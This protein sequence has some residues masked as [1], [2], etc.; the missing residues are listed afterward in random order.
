M[1]EEEADVGDSLGLQAIKLLDSDSYNAPGFIKL[2]S[3]C[4]ISTV[5]TVFEQLNSAHC[6]ERLTKRIT[7]T[8]RMTLPVFLTTS[9][10]I[11]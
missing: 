8:T 4:G 5:I 1:L 10:V 6:L 7:E 9:V 2:Y 11:I 3:R